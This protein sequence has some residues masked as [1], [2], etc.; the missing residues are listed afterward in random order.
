MLRM[1]SIVISTS[2]T[3]AIGSSHIALLLVDSP[4]IGRVSAPSS[5]IA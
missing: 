2:M 4:P 1:V 3:A 5:R